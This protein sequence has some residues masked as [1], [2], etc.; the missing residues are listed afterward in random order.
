MIHIV[1]VRVGQKYGPE[2][3]LHLHD[4]IARHLHEEQRHWCLTDD[5]ESLPEGITA[6]PHNPDLPGWWQ[7]VFLFSPDMPWREGDEVL[8]MDLDVCVTGRLEELPHGII[9]DWHYDCYNSSVMRWRHGDYR[10][11][12]DGF[13]P[14]VMQAY[15]GDQDYI[16]AVSRWPEFDRRW[17]VSYRSHARAWPPEGSKAVI[18]HGRPNPHE[19]LDGWVPESWRV[20]GMTAL[21]KLTGSNTV[22]ETV[23]SNVRENL[24]R[25]L[26][27]FSGFGERKGAAVLVCG[28]PSLLDNIE[29][30]KAHKR[31]GARIITVNNAH[32]VLMSRNI[33]PDGHVL[34]DARAENRAFVED[35]PDIPY[36]VAS[37]CHPDLVGDLLEQ[38]RRVILWHNGIPGEELREILDPWWEEKPCVIVPG[39]GTVGLRALNLLWL[40]GYKKIHI[41]GMDSSYRDGAH[42]AYAQSLNDGERVIS[43]V[44]GG[45]TYR[46]ATWM[47]RQA[48]EFKEAW[49]ILKS[50]GVKLFVHGEGLIPDI[51]KAMT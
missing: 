26:P 41:Y 24:G 2:Y 15:A 29:N 38:G 34:L 46:C 21:P 5:P 13:S 39:G 14:D 10:Q 50:K 25:D 51:A 36:F 4:A 47:A 19:V 30:I 16:H 20:G 31:R 49:H 12:W 8:Y 48:D 37:Q 33:K 32:R 7:K 18:F 44:H 1:S 22:R 11:V 6:I 28:G 43:V 35:A 23:L 9:R 40:S 27:W 45:K 17:F 3:V 42:H